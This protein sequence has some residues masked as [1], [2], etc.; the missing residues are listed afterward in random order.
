M[1]EAENVQT[2]NHTT[3]SDKRK[4]EKSGGSPGGASSEA[5]D[6]V[7][8]CADSGESNDVVDESHVSLT[9]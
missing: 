7:D 9:R 4:R 2:H 8:G 3:K 5:V 6:D 1:K